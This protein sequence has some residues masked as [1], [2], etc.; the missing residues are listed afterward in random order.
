MAVELARVVRG[1]MVESVHR[2]SIAVVDSRGRLVAFAGD[3]ASVICLRSVAKPFQ[4]VPLLEYGGLEEFDLS[5]EEIALTCASHGGETIHVATAAALLRKGE[6]DEED[7]L[8]GAHLPFDEKAAADL[9][10]SGEAPSTLHNNCSGKHAGMLLGTQIM[11]LPAAAYTAPDHPLQDLMRA[12]LAEF[13][14]VLPDDV[15]FAIDG[16]GAPAYF[17]TLYRTAFAY[18]RL[19]A[20][21]EGSAAPGALTKYGESASHIVEAMTAFPEYVAGNWSMTT[22]LMSA[23]GGGLLAKDGA[24]GAY[25]MA[26]SPAQCGTLRHTLRVDEDCTLG[27]ALKID[28]GSMSR[29]RNQA[30]LRVLDLLGLDLDSRPELDP[31]RRAPLHNHRGTLVGELRAEFLLEEL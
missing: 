28:D 30:I 31:W 18:A 26:I 12:T 25:A 5:G 21:S 13:A 16:C 15:P 10:A 11:D 17:L 27:V 4:G 7:L 8:C 9:R 3:P 19:M 2:G 14:G 24:E 23:F 6:F 20:T 1:G 29:G 22:P